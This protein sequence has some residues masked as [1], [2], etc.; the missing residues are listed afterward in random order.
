MRSSSSAAHGAVL[1]AT[2][3]TGRRRLL[4]G[5]GALSALGLSGCASPAADARPPAPQ[6][7]VR[8][9]DQWRYAQ[10]NRYNG[11][12]LGE[13]TMRVVA[14]TPLLRVA[15]SGWGA[16]PEGTEE[17]YAGPWNVLQEPTYDVL[18]RFDTP[19]PLLPERLQPGA[20]VRYAGRYRVPGSNESFE[21]YAWADAIR[22]EQ[23]SV[24]AGQ[25]DTIR[26]ERRISFRHSDLWHVR[27][28]RQETIWYAPVVNRWVRRE[29]TGN[30]LRYGMERYF[31]LREDWI[32]SQLVE[33]AP[34]RG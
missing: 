1:P 30:Y 16:P 25:F 12:G 5:A 26:I 34:A 7:Q 8:V 6:P 27:S 19:Q 4:V 2:P 31:R 32:A 24:P 28:E 3:R 33:Y 18:Q 21:W 11:L 14:V 20:K 23:T 10:V 13:T 17:T 29:W 15:V 9:G 22:W